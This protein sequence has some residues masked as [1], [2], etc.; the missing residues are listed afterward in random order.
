M[1]LDLFLNKKIAVY[2]GFLIYLIYLMEKSR[3]KG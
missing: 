3:F 1:F 2:G